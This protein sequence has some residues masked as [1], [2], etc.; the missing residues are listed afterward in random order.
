M[1]RTVPQLILGLEE[2]MDEPTFS[3]S[4]ISSKRLTLFDVLQLTFSFIPKDSCIGKLKVD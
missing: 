1:E 2:I 3:K 4:L